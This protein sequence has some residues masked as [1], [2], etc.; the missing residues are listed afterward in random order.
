M[1]GAGTAR[2]ELRI[3]RMR[4]ENPLPVQACGSRAYRA[5]VLVTVL[6]VPVFS[7]ANVGNA[8]LWF[9]ECS[10]GG[11][12]ATSLHF[13][14]GSRPER[15]HGVHYSGSLEE[16]A[17]ERGGT[18]MEAANFGFVTASQEESY[19]E[20]RKRVAAK[21]SAPITFVAVESLHRPG[22]VRNSKAYLTLP[23]E[24]TGDWHEQIGEIR[25]LFS[26]A[27]VTTSE[28]RP[29]GGTPRTFLHSILAVIRSADNVFASEYVHN[30]NLFRLECEKAADKHLT[31][32]TGR[33]R[34]LGN[35][36]M[37]SFR[38][39]LEQGSDYPARIEFQPRSYL[40]IV[41]EPDP[42]AQ[43]PTKEAV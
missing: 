37:A 4:Q 29:A 40:R 43:L 42:P 8:F 41:L 17:V 28:L 35:G 7:R 20:A 25:S 30:G 19:A 14:G 27:R 34:N 33:T 26:T 3:D 31:R 24:D 15:A 23:C 2:G 10:S 1:A 22:T 5:D 36:R 38:F 16:A 39:W 6:G 9:R 13:A 21:T 32:V 11:L 12:R 18:L